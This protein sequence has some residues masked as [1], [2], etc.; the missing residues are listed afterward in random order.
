MTAFYIREENIKYE[1]STIHSVLSSDIM[2]AIV[3]QVLATNKMQYR[4]INNY[5]KA[6]VYTGNFSK[7]IGTEWSPIHPC[8]NN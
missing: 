5:L 1:R 6:G 2:L 7:R 4:G 8:E 3:W